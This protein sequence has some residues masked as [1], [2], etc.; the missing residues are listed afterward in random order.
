M[1]SDLPAY[2]QV[3]LLVTVLYPRSATL[4]LSD[5]DQGLVVFCCLCNFVE[6]IV[7]KSCDIAC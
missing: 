2:E 5:K 6:Q 3:F 4:F 7:S 1:D